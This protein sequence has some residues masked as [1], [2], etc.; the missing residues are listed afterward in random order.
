MWDTMKALSPALRLLIIS[1]GLVGLAAFGIRALF[2]AQKGKDA[3]ASTETTM[4]LTLATIPPI[5]AAAPAR[6]ET[7]TFGLG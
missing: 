2:N 7:A 6:F 4:D 3:M 5:D 1:I